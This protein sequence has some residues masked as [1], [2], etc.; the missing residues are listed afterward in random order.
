MLDKQVS[1]LQRENK[2][3]K[4]KLETSYR[5]QH[6]LENELEEFQVEA[7]RKEEESKSSKRKFQE[8]QKTHF[9][10]E[11]EKKE[12]IDKLA[13]ADKERAKINDKYIKLSQRLKDGG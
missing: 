9:N 12:M 2:E 6:Q 11:K 3:L 8:F 5:M 13:K 7:K 10:C 1:Q 4:D